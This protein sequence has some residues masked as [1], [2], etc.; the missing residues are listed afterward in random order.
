MLLLSLVPL[1]AVVGEQWGCRVSFPRGRD[2]SFV[3]GLWEPTR[4]AKIFLAIRQRASQPILTP[5]TQRQF[6]SA[7]LKSTVPPAKAT[8]PVRTRSLPIRR[9]GNQRL[10][11]SLLLGMLVAHVFMVFFVLFC[12]SQE[13]LK[14]EGLTG[15]LGKVPPGNKSSGGGGESWLGSGFFLHVRRAIDVRMGSMFCR[16]RWC[17]FWLPCG[18]DLRRSALAFIHASCPCWRPFDGLPGC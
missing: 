18:C 2:D 17:I 15:R 14:K 6:H 1:L 12:F 16:C 9:R 11:F 13:F 10:R 4:R 7:L 5:C 3:C 8:L